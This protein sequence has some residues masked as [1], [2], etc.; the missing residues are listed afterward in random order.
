MVNQPADRL[1]VRSDD[2]VVLLLGADQTQEI[3]GEVFGSFL[4]APTIRQVRAAAK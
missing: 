4:P 3:V 2:A 1:S